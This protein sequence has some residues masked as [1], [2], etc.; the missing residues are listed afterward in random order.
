[1]IVLRDVFGDD[2]PERETLLA[3]YQQTIDAACAERRNVRP[4]HPGHMAQIGW[5]AGPRHARVFQAAKSYTKNLDLETRIEH[6]LYSVAALSL[7]WA[8]LKALA[9]SDIPDTI[10]KTLADSG[11]PKIATRD[12]PEGEWIG[13][14]LVLKGKTYSFR[15]DRAPPRSIYSVKPAPP[16][17]AAAPASSVRSRLR[18]GAKNSKTPAPPSR[19]P[20]FDDTSLWPESGGGNFVDMSLRVVI[21]QATGTLFMFNPTHRHGTTRLCGAHNYTASFTFSQHIKDAFDKANKGPHIEAGKGAG[22][23][24]FDLK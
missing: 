4:N 22:D 6:D 12:V 23:G 24:N 8:L 15:F 16:T 21:E 19:D 20:L 18:S 13:F 9:P 3:W 14:R 10:E 11:L 2:S 17:T 7:T 1:L 5:N